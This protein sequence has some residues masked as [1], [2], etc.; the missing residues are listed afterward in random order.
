MRLCTSRNNFMLTLYAINSLAGYK[1]IDLYI[2]FFLR[3]L[4]T[5]LDVFLNPVCS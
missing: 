1:N 3:A 2:F 5:L 4:M